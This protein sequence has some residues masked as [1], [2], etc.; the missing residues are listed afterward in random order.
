MVIME[1]LL[2]SVCG[3]L[4]VYLKT[5]NGKYSAVTGGLQGFF[6]QDPRLWLQKQA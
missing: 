3:L 6:P 5:K 4:K 1:M 2:L